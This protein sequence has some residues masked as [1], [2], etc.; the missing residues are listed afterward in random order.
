MTR[1]TVERVRSGASFD[2]IIE[3]LDRFLHYRDEHETSISL[4]FCLMTENWHEFGDF[5]RFAEARGCRVYVNTVRQPPAF[6]LFRLPPDELRR[7][8]DHLESVRDST[9]AE[10]DLNRHVWTDQLD[11][12]RNH[13]DASPAEAAPAA[14]PGHAEPSQIEYWDGLARWTTSPDATEDAIVE[15]VRSASCDGNASIARCDG[16]DNVREAGDYLGMDVRH[17]VG[18]PAGELMLLAADHLGV[19]IEVHSEHVSHG[20]VCRVVSFGSPT[21]SPSYVLSLTRRDP[22]TAGTTRIAAVLLRGV[23]LPDV[24]TSVPISISE[25]PARGT[26]A[27]AASS[28]PS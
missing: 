26:A 7:I 13:V 15:A 17:L 3:N 25:G 21:R 6:S 20:A 8:V 9:A 18:R 12:L 4:T 1:E 14:P 2:R 19:S 5:L 27:A 22:S 11:R 10:L 24:A 23:P 16:A 28:S